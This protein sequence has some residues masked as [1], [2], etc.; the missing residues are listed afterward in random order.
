MMS[1]MMMFY[2][3]TSLSLFTVIWTAGMAAM[4][5][6]A[7]SPMVL[8]YDRLIKTNNNTSNS[9]V[10]TTSLKKRAGEAPSLVFDKDNK[11]ANKKERRGKYYYF[12]DPFGHHIH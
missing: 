4:M 12:Q 10:K 1:T 3:P 5:F 11:E 9:N 6:P 2:N 7:I 8:L